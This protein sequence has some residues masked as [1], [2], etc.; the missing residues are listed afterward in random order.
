MFDLSSFSDNKLRYWTAVLTTILSLLGLLV[1]LSS[2]IGKEADMHRSLAPAFTQLVAWILGISAMFTLGSCGSI[3]RVRR[4]LIWPL[5][6]F[7][8]VLLIW[9]GWFSE[10]INNVH[11]WIS[12]RSISFQ[13]SEL[14][15]LA[16]IFLW[17][18]YLSRHSSKVVKLSDFSSRFRK[19]KSEHAETKLSLV[20]FLLDLLNGIVIFFK[21]FWVP[22]IVTVI[23]V[24]LFERGS[25]LGTTVLMSAVIFC[26]VF[27]V[28]FSRKVLLT[29]MTCAFL[30]V[31]YTVL[32][33][34]AVNISQLH[35]EEMQNHYR[36][37]RMIGWRHTDYDPKG[38]NYQI[39][40]ALAAISSGG[41]FGVGIP[42]SRSRYN[43]IPEMHC[44]FIYSIYSEEMGLLGVLGLFCLF[45][46]FGVFGLTIANRS[47]NE[48]LSL[49]AFGIT[50][51][52]ICQLLYNISVV[53]GLMPNKGL[54]L[55]FFSHGGS[56]L[57]MSFISVGLLLNIIHHSE[58][59][60][61]HIEEKQ[62]KKK[63]PTVAVTSDSS[64]EKHESISGDD[65]GDA[66]EASAAP[67]ENTSSYNALPKPII[68]CSIMSS[69][70]LRMLRR[71]GK[72][73]K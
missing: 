36:K 23:F 14:G 53:T 67:V 32:S 8:I 31:L 56:S 28:G 13:P 4:L 29:I 59:A 22:L 43:F 2:S 1:L 57:M 25:D 55:P 48:F 71:S 44:D 69:E 18:E 51:Q 40:N 10:A 26:M 19:R 49:A 12:F 70:D 6:I 3:A 5:T 15:K 45:F 16:L 34:D 64:Y 38:V 37:E 68:S 50:T 46:A 60:E 52:I 72:A 66:W 24:G 61:K 17:A 27:M 54:P 42:H 58:S 9:A 21:L 62:V 41:L 39:R 20:N 35:P 7:T 65:S 11:R 63:G 47:K 30:I 73:G 33:L